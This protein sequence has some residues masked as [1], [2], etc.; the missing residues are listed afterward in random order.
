MIIHQS[1]T[2]QSRTQDQLEEASTHKS[3][4]THTGTVFVTRDLDP[5][6]NGFPELVV[7][8]CMSSLMILAASVFEIS[9]EKTEKRRWISNPPPVTAVGVGNEAYF[10]KCTINCFTCNVVKC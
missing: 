1:D 9:C 3:A 2:C 10:H 8:H 4:M 6:I 5:K 7:E